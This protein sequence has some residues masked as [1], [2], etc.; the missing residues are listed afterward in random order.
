MPAGRQ[1]AQVG[2]PGGAADLGE[3]SRASSEVSRFLAQPKL[4]EAVGAA[5]GDAGQAEKARR[6]A[7]E[8][9][10]SHGVQ[11]PP[12]VK[13]VFEGSGGAAA[14]KIEIKVSCCPLNIEIIIYL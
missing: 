4:A 9:L 12:G 14:R 13:V 2:M 3:A 10:T 1:A 8:F 7:N 6:N 11:V 5:R